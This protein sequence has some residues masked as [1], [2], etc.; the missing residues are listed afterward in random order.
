MAYHIP[1]CS[2]TALSYLVPKMHK[3][4]LAVN[5]K[6][7]FFFNLG[8]VPFLFPPHPSPNTSECARVSVTQSYCLIMAEVNR[9]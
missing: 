6:K 3:I 8:A 5:I 7:P 9:T 2:G 1:H 4:A